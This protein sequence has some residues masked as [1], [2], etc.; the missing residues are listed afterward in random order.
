METALCA[1]SL[2]PLCVWGVC[3]CESNEIMLVQVFNVI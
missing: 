3:V 2:P 1:Y